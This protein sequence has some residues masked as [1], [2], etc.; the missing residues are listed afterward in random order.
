MDKPAAIRPLVTKLSDL[1][2]LSSYWLA[3]NFVW[4]TLLPIV[5]PA[6]VEAL[7]PLAAL[8]TRQGLLLGL[9]ALVSA[10]LQLTIGY[11]S[12]STESRFGRRKPYIAIGTA[13]AIVSILFFISTGTYLGL[14][15][16]YFAVQIAMNT[17]SVPYQSMMPDLV[18]EQHHG[19]AAMM[20]GIFSLAGNISGLVLSALVVGGMLGTTAAGKPSYLVLTILYCL[21]LASLAVAVLLKSPSYP[22]NLAVRWM[23][24]N[25]GG[26]TG[27][28]EFFRGLFRYG[29]KEHPDFLK[30]MLCRTCI[31][32]GYYTIVFFIYRF[33]KTNLGVGEHRGL[34]A[35]LLVT[36]IVGAVAGNIIGG[37][38]CDTIGKRKVIYA[39]MSASGVLLLPIIFAHDIRVAIYF[40]V[41]LGVA[42]GAFIAADRAFAYTLI[43]KENAAR[44]MGFWDLTTLVPQM[45]AP[46]LAGI[47]RDRLVSVLPGGA[48]GAEAQTYRIIF[49]FAIL[50]FVLGLIVL[51]Y[52]K[53]PKGEGEAQ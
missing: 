52:V 45:I 27:I 17:A 34:A 26:R 48:L 24:L 49:A 44:Y 6:R 19:R 33:A 35:V 9:G 20:M 3:I 46:F 41:F 47:A 15:L 43:P 13:L 14:L 30:L 4:A 32:F 50:Y 1:A 42:W 11:V 25:L 53:E 38:L 36:I 2:W 7:V 23:R 8:G 37:K 51:G 12:D 40:G 28:L 10:L 18:P 29:F 21:L 5:I 31:L 16:A 39:S 22:V